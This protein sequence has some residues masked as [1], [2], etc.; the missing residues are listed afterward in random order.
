MDRG[1]LVP[2]LR[3]LVLRPDTPLDR[4]VKE[5]I[6]GKLDSAED[7]FAAICG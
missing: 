4:G 3:E 7:R 2:P 6:A 5:M 1:D